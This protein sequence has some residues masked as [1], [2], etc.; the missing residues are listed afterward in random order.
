M[1]AAQRERLARLCRDA[2]AR[3]PE[4]LADELFLLIEGA[5]VCS[6]SLG[7]GGPSAHAVRMG[8]DLIKAHLG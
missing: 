6:Q 5:R 4:R 8:E 1:K 3:D 2:G 7:P